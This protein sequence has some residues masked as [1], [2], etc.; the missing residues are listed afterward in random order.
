[1]GVA[2]SGGGSGGATN[3]YFNVTGDATDQTL[4]RM[5]DMAER[6]F[7]SRAPGVV[8]QSVGAVR[9]EIVRDAGYT[10]R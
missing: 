4:A 6:V 10:R 2:A 9:R 8:K 5:K 1:L 7:S 3:V